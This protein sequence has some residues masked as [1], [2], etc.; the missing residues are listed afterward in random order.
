MKPAVH[1]EPLD[2][3]YIPGLKELPPPEWN[4]DIVEFMNTYLGNEFFHAIVARAGG[5][6]IGVGNVFI[7]GKRAWLGNIIVH[8]SC[9]RRHI[10]TRITTMLMERAARSRCGTVNLMATAVGK[11]LY[12]T[13]GFTNATTYL[14]YKGGLTPPPEGDAHIRP[15]DKND[16]DGV[17][18]LDSAV[19]GEDRRFM[20]CGHAEKGYVYERTD[21]IR[22]FYLPDMGNGM[23]ISDDTEAG[24][25]LLKLKH[26]TGDR[27]SVFPEENRA[28]SELLLGCGFIE[29]DRSSRMCRGEDYRWNPENVFCR[30]AGYIG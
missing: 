16:C 2:K 5:E 17:F 10:G 4:H 19:T 21:G 9:R 1:I 22:A 26:S 7:T 6:T 15:I 12:S 11:K 14:F 3:A 8:P 29:Y 20:L 27:I 13:L 18:A 28:A 23:I 30:I 24:L 25:E